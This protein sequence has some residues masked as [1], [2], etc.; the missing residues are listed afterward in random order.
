MIVTEIIQ[1]EVGDEF[2]LTKS[3][4]GFYIRQTETGYEYAEAV[5]PLDI[6][7]E[8]TETDRLIEVP[9]TQPEEI[10]ETETE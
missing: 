1:N 10:P 8:Y 7:R 4:S 5:D 2:R 9:E 6:V 3:D